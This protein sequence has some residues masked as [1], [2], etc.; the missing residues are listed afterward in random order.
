MDNTLS[1][2]SGQRR[3][4]QSLPWHLKTHKHTQLVQRLWLPCSEW[5]ALASCQCIISPRLF[6]SLLVEYLCSKI[7]N[8]SRHRIVFFPPAIKGNWSD[9]R[10]TTVHLG[11]LPPWTERLHTFSEGMRK[12]TSKQVLLLLCWQQQIKMSLLSVNSMNRITKNSAWS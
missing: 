5:L 6:M 10:R 9:K 8:L 4:G 2:Q 12:R 7:T 11:I 1:H 3:G